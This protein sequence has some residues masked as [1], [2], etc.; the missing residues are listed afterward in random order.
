MSPTSPQSNTQRV[1]QGIRQRI[2]H[3][4]ITPG[5]KLKVASLKTLFETGASPVREALSLLTSDL[6]VE[7]IDQ[8]G[9]RAA[10]ASVEHFQE[11]RLLR[12]QLESLALRNSIQRM[13]IQWEEKLVLAH[14]HLSQTDRNQHDEWEKY[15]RNFH[16]CL[17]ENC[18]S[19]ILLRFCSQL[20]DLNIRYR[21]LA[22]QSL[23]YQ[24]RDIEAEHK[25]ILN[26][27]LDNQEDTAI[28]Q[29]VRHY[30]LTGEY[31]SDHM[32]QTV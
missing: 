26:A 20:Y 30:E 31:L 27:V 3:G 32:V 18:G 28:Q 15:H 8:R 14:H 21:N 1:Y 7:R 4:V 29:L 13:Q 5:E 24:K 10:P 6:L 25:S 9:F 16:I 12:C 23:S 2:I 17:L 19:P 11:I 22:G